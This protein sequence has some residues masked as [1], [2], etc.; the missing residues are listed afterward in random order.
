MK[1]QVLMT[2]QVAMYIEADDQ[3]DAERRAEVVAAAVGGQ[4]YTILAGG[5]LHKFTTDSAE[6]LDVDEA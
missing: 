6:V 3:A 5:E 1:A 4:Q 2:V